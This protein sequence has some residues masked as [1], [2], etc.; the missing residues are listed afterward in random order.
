[1]DEAEARVGRQIDELT[2]TAV[3]GTPLLEISVRDPDPEVAR[4]LAEAVTDVLTER[5]EAGEI[6]VEALHLSTLDRAAVSEDSVYP[7]ERLTLLVAGL[8]GLA[9]GAGVAFLGEMLGAKVGT[10]EGVEELTGIPC[11]AEIPT[12]PAVSRVLLPDVLGSDPRL[13]RL[14]EALRDLRTNLQLNEGEFRSIVITSP[15]GHHGKSTI[16]TGL[17][18]TIAQSGRRTLLIDAD[19]RRGRVSELLGIPPTT[20]LMEALTGA[21]IQELVRR[22]SVPDLDVLTRGGI[23]EDPGDLLRRFPSVLRHVQA[24]Y[25]VVVCDTT[26]VAPVNDARVLASYADTVILVV[27]AETATRRR[28]KAAVSRLDILSVRPTA[29]VLNRSRGSTMS[30]YYTTVPER[31]VSGRTLRA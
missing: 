6:G 17:A 25:D 30:D 1:V 7:R 24:L 26:P 18:T 13:R 28:L 12:E 21:P 23:V 14:H 9:L 4:E 8:L 27:S 19:M 11:F 2:V 10:A 5:V 22:T 16:A 20:G 3:G 15:D 31:D 29:F